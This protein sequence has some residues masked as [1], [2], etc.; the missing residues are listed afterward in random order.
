MADPPSAVTFP[1]THWS[2]VAHAVD[3]AAP[4]APAAL[5]ELCGAYWYPIY[6]FIRRNRNDPAL[7]LDLAQ[8]YF[9]RLLESD[10]LASTDHRR[11]RFRAAAASQTIEG[12]P[13]RADRRDARRPRRGHDRRRDQRPV[14]RARPLVDGSPEGPASG[15]LADPLQVV[16]R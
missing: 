3:P 4:K 8:D 1:T 15:F 13:P 6:A 14:H 10:V 7:A 5:A 16:R 9:T 12:D 11:G 2:R